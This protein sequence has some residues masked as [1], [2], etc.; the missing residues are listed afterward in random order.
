LINA[1]V[2]P[3]PL[4]VVS[5]F[6]F[7]AVGT[8]AGTFNVASQTFN[9]TNAG[10]SALVWSLVNTSVWLTASSSGGTLAAGTGNSVTVNLNTAGSNLI[11]GTYLASLSFSNVTSHV[12]HYRNF[13]LKTTDPLVILP[14]AKFMFAGPPG[15]PFAPASKG[16]ILTNPSPG[17]VNWSLNNTSVWFNVSPVSGSILPAAQAGL[18]FTLAPAVANLPDG[19]YSVTFQITNLATLSVQLV[20]GVVSVGIIQNGGFETGDFTAWTLAGNG[21]DGTNLYDG[22]VNASSLTDGSG[23][24][25]IHSGTY[26]AFLGDTNLATLSQSFQTVPGQNY[27]LSFWLANPATGA[28]QQFSVGW[29]TNSP[30]ANQI[31]FITN[32]PVL[33]WTNI[34]FVV[35]ATGTNTTL[36]FGAQNPPDGFGLDDVS[37]DIILP[38][39]I[40]SQPTNLTVLAGNTAI[41]GASVNGSVPLTYQWLK[42][43]VSLANGSG[44]SGATTPSLALAGV[45]TNSAA[46]YTLVVTNFYGAATSSVAVLTVLV[47]PTITGL[48]NQTIQCGGNATFAINANGAPPLSYQW[49]LDGTPVPS[50]TSNSLALVNVHLPSHTVAVTVTNLYGSVASNAVLTVQDTIAPV[51][52]LNGANPV[53]VELGGVFSD[54][55]ATANDACAGPVPVATNGLVNVNAVGTNLLAYISTDGNGN[56]NIVTRAV[57]VRDTTPPTIS[58]SFTNLVLAANTNCS[59]LMPDVTGTNFIVATDLSGALTVS[60]NPTNNFTLALGTNLVVITVADASGNAAYSTNRIIVQDQTPPVILT[61]PQ[62]QTNLAGTTANFSVTATACTSLAYQWF[63]TNTA[64]AGQTNGTLTLASVS[65]NSAGN[66]T[67][68]VSASGG[69][70]T[71]AVAILSVN[72]GGVPTNAI[73]KITGV[74]A[75]PDGSFSL[76]LAG[77]VGYT[78]I[79]ETATNFL[80]PIGWLP[81][82]TNTL[83]TNGVWQFT[84]ARATNFVQQFYRL[85]LAP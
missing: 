34:T 76:N 53:Y 27:L 66:Y 14:P 48:T 3:D 50:A 47:P 54:P 2:S 64:L 35:T 1:L 10:T 51:I 25:F 8:P 83:G 78:Y 33:A 77:G 5:N 74:A 19:L 68:V 85:K 23:P 28:G 13:T 52:T 20:T 41:F 70:T 46:N 84:D 58:M 9:I 17:T 36:Q 62:S 12:G 71:S 16:I 31:Y 24:N 43:G 21:Y 29:I 38:P 57:I 26:G 11:A 65:T 18:T 82:A 73:P 30:A 60:Q 67:V 49:S 80:P 79:L 6:G 63:F 61:Q 4:I 59:A 44:I 15:G 45:T 56:T 39:A 37:V 32:P 22:V 72:L 55:G 69:S 81:V 75:N 42:N 7:Q 40:I